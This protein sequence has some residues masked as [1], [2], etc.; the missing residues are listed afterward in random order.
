MAKGKVILLC[1]SCGW[2]LV[3]DNDCPGL[4]E[5]K[6][7]TLS[8]RKF[9]CKGCGRAIAPRKFPDPQAE[10]NMKA[11][12]ERLKSENEAFMSETMDFQNKFVKGLDEQE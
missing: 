3:C 11:N 8:A 9:R 12:E 10:A 5:V 7:D 6:T 1:S 4:T 2:K